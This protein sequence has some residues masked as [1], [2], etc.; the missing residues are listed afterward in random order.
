[1]IQH[2]NPNIRSVHSHTSQIT[3]LIRQEAHRLGFFK[4]GIAPARQLPHSERFNSWI[5]NGFHGEMRYMERRAAKRLD[6]AKV[7]SG[8]RSLVVV[9]MKYCSGSAFMAEPLKGFIS[10]YA[11]GDDYH[12][13]VKTRL[14]QLLEFIRV[15]VPSVNGLCY[16]DTGPLME[17]VWG[18]QTAIGWMGKHTNL[19]TREQGS[20][21]F[22]GTI[23]LDIDLECDTPEKDFCGRCRRCIDACP[24]GA[25][26]APYVLDA[27]R[28]VSYLTIELRG[29]I[30][31]QL[32]SQIGNRIYG[33]DECQEVCPWNKFAVDVSA[34]ALKPR[35]EN[36]RPDLVQLVHLT[37]A[38]FE[39]RFEGSAILRA[40]RDGFVRNV[41]VA[42]GNSG[43]HQAI[44]ALRQAL[45][46]SSPLVRM[47][48]EWAIRNIKNRLPNGETAEA[49]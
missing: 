38:Q 24:T 31:E 28:C 16:V 3:T 12:G 34:E 41:A 6:P 15:L 49:G 22:L 5:K 48:A 36:L 9:A 35:S 18:A 32:R 2:S 1:M 45:L 47:H 20:W 7:L 26:V 30:P 40:T 29:S 42:L 14:E 27:R 39:K 13:I 4:T 46:D 10:R 37:K 19:I 23:L 25:I 8:A 21:F 17:K 33:C 44:P 11:W 43:A